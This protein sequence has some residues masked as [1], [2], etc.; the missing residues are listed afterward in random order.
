MDVANPGL[1]DFCL[2]IGF[3]VGSICFS[4]FYILEG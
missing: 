1:V 4:R 2:M 3:V